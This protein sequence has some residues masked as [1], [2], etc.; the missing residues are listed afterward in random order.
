MNG[1]HGMPILCAATSSSHRWLMVGQDWF[2]NDIDIGSHKGKYAKLI[3]RVDDSEQLA[4]ALIAMYNN[5]CIEH[6]SEWS[7]R[8]N[9]RRKTH[10]VEMESITLWINHVC[11]PNGWSYRWPEGQSLCH[12]LEFTVDHGLTWMTVQM[13]T[14]ANHSPRARASGYSLP[15]MHQAGYNE[16]G[17]PTHKPYAIGDSDIYI[18]MRWND[19]YVDV[20]TFTEDELSEY[21]STSD[22]IGKPRISIHLPSELSNE[23]VN[24]GVSKSKGGPINRTLWTRRNHERYSRT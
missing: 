19:E 8:W 22:C 23:R 10:L 15:L 2:A 24:D 17:K 6:V 1:Y 4:G 11:V 12:D 5:E 13:K 21:L 7:A 16:D 20:W 9:I 3:N 18:G 14:V